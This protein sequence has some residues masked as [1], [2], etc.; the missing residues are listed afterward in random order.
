[1]RIRALGGTFR[2][3]EINVPGDKSISH[4]AVML[5]A[6]ADGQSVVR[7]CLLGGDVLSTIG[8]FRDM[9]VEINTEGGTVFVHGVGIA[10]LQSP[11]R[12]L[13]AGNA[14]TCMRLLSGVLS[15]QPFTSTIVGD[16]SLSK[17]PMSRVIVPLERMEAKIRASE[18]GTAP[19]TIEGRRPL[20]AITYELPV[21]S[22]QIKSAVLLAGLYADAVTTV[23]EPEMVRDHT[24]RMLSAFGVRVARNGREVSITPSSLSAQEVVVPADISSAAF[25]MVAALISEDCG[26]TIRGVGANPLRTGVIDILR[27]MG[28]RL[29][30]KNLRVVNGE[31]VADIE[32]RSSDLRGIEIS[33]EWVSR[34]IDELPVV[35]IAAAFAEGVTRI[36]GAAELR[37]KESD[38]IEAMVGGLRG[39]GVDATPTPDGAIIRGQS[40]A[41]GG[42]RVQTYFDHRI[43][44]SFAIAGLRCDEPLLIDDA[45]AIFTS[46]PSFTELAG[47]SGISLV[48]EP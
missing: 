10:G 42:V 16:H 41:A 22:A 9:G 21:P 44:M 4:R 36:S 19:L 27:A 31:E 17:R 28:G 24:E 25:F 15:G 38:R 20:R 39:I 34:A 43:A 3:G 32:I 18:S 2:S 37:V 13:D 12:P 1:M 48:C 30:V 23:I 33:E 6:L 11:K 47:G 8:C 45:D 29:A 7:G 14:G 40:R 35:M 46:F 5:G 26:L